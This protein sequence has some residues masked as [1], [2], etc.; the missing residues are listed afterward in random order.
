MS[1]QG[2]SLWTHVGEA[3]AGVSARPAR[4]ALTMLGEALGLAALVATIGLAGTANGQVSAH[5]DQAAADRVTVQPD[6]ARA[7]RG[8]LLPPDSET[9]IRRLEGVTAAGT[10]SRLEI[11]GAVHTVPVVDPLAPPDPVLPVLAASPGLFDATGARIS[12]RPYD[13]GHAARADAVALLGAAAAR[14]LG[15]TDLAQGPAVFID[16]HALTVVGVIDAVDSRGELLDSVVIPEPTAA[17]LFGWKGAQSLQVDVAPNAAETIARQAPLAIAPQDPTGITASAPPTD[18]TLRERVQGDVSSLLV[19]LGIV[20]LVA[21]GVGIANVM[22]LSVMERV[23]EIG[24]R[25]ALGATRGNLMTQ[26]L[27]ESATVGLLGGIVGTSLGFVTTMV[28]ALGRDW[29]PVLDS[30]LLAAPLAGLI[31]G[32]LAGA[33]PAWRAGSLEPVDALRTL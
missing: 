30:R 32:V 10:L 29:T 17:R 24:L 20:A 9:S 19:L 22:L 21:G 23:G 7:E 1:R 11:E 33:F 14:R 8:A 18:S 2:A 28:V 31:V 13:E 12:G 25:R 15:V 26:F 6:E 27:V 4:L 5:F 3:M 16:D